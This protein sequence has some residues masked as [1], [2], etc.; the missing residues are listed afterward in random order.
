VELTRNNPEDPTI[1][2]GK[3][4]PCLEL[5]KRVSGDGGLNFVDADNCSDADVPFTA[6]DAVYE[7][8]VTNCGKEA[9]DLDRIVDLDL[10]INL[11]LDPVVTI[12]LGGTFIF[13]NNAG[14]T[15]GLLQKE[16][17]CPNID[18]EFDNTATV[19]GTGAGGGDS[20][21]ATD[22]ACVKCGPCIDL[23]KE[24]SVD[25][26]QSWSDANDPEC[27]DGP[28]TSDP[29][30]YRLTIENC[31]GEVL[32]NVVI[33]DD[34]LGIDNVSVGQTIPIGGSII[35]TKD[36]ISELGKDD[37]CPLTPDDPGVTDDILRNI[38][39][40]DAQGETSEIPVFDED[41][42]CVK[43][44][45][46]EEGC[47]T[48]TPGFW[49]THDRVTELF[50]P[51]NSCGIELDNIEAATGGSAIE[52]L[53]FSGRDFK[54]SDT[55]PQQ[56]Q[57]IRQCTAA[58]LNFAA[59]EAAGGSCSDIVLSDGQTIDEVFVA[60]CEDLCTSGASGPTI[61]GSNCIERLDEFNNL[62]SDTLTCETDP[63]APFPFC[64]SLGANGFNATP[65]TCEEANGNGFVNPGR[66][67]GPK[68]GGG[69]NG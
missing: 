53:N 6:D 31:G 45:E 24:V 28:S 50:L 69:R 61:S 1:D 17:A 4:G 47:L 21:E 32:V 3:V 14:P 22:P 41:P 55:S 10:G 38:A 13:T 62:E 29:A 35:L 2:C 37:L 8:I 59:S 68:N 51:V 42:A 54:A 64:P 60:C 49:C 27:S 58:A 40:V 16:G 26:G 34:V 19:F 48:R 46:E 39:R 36:D 25:D 66:N 23:I 5:E 67:L 9:V 12:P 18:G 33:D 57:L 20:V 43:C 56:L 63:Q 65:A 7:L 44:E 15:Q 30:E 11:V 52:D